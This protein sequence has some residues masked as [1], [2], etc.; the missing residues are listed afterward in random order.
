MDLAEP[1]KLAAQLLRAGK[2][3]AFV[4][5]RVLSQYPKMTVADWSEVFY[6]KEWTDASTEYLGA[7]SLDFKSRVM[8][9][10]TKALST[11][12]RLATEE[13]IDQNIQNKAAMHLTTLAAKLCADRVIAEAAVDQLPYDE[14]I[15]LLRRA[16]SQMAAM[17][18]SE[19]ALDALLV[20]RDL[21]PEF[22]QLYEPVGG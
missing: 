8:R 10:G 13:D 12:E 5:K 20:L 18:C 22:A 7:H 4:K 1:K 9:A 17:I 21:H 15:A 19:D 16:W 2:P 6:S 11:L 3:A 14:R